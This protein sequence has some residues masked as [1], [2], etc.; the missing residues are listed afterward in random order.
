MGTRRDAQ[1]IAQPGLSYHEDV[2]RPPS[3]QGDPS[4]VRRTHHHGWLRDAPQPG[5]RRHGRQD[6]IEEGAPLRPCKQL[7][8][9]EPARTPRG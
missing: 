5:E 6:M 1:G 4:L 7:V 3:S 8:A 9:P 2:H